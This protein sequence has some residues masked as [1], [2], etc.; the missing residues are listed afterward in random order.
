[1][2]RTQ[3]YRL[4]YLLGFYQKYQRVDWAGVKRLVFVCK[5]N[6]CRSAFGEAVAKAKGI[7]AASFGIDT[8]DDAP[9]NATAIEVAHEK[10]IDL[11]SHRTRQISGYKYQEGDLLLAMEPWQASI[12]EDQFGKN[13]QITLLGIW[14]EVKLPHLGDP[15]NTSLEYF[16][17]CFSLISAN[18]SSI[19]SRF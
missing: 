14:A 4:L 2:L 16:Q 15:F 8:I 9:A 19:S 1:M 12:L 10:G 11:T 3:W 7:S 6:I 5:G 17:R 13:T 18:V